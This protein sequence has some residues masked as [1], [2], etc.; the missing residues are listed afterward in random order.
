MYAPPKD[1]SYKTFNFTEANGN[2][3]RSISHK[4]SSHFSNGE[5]N[6]T[7][8]GR[9]NT[10]GWANCNCKASGSTEMV[11]T[12]PTG[13]W[14]A[15]RTGVYADSPL[16]VA[17]PD[18]T[19]YVD[20]D[21]CPSKTVVHYDPELCKDLAKSTHDFTSV[22]QEVYRELCRQCA[23]GDGIFC[24]HRGLKYPTCGLTVWMQAAF[25]LVGCLVIKAAYMMAT[26]LRS[27]KRLK[28]T[29]P[30]IWRLTC[31]QR[32]AVRYPDTQRMLDKCR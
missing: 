1:V 28:N 2:Y 13:C 23:V 16:T 11:G 26:N 32:H 5:W 7:K 25:I 31:C 18:G 17:L 3:T 21:A 15:F 4:N 6:N 12:G 14:T 22:W 29:L 10:T 30:D 19:L 27:R 9:G 20:K 8:L 24:E